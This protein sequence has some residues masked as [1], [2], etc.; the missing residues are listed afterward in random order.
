MFG[1]QLVALERIARD[2]RP[3]VY[4]RV[5]LALIGTL[6]HDGKG[7]ARVDG[8]VLIVSSSLGQRDGLFGSQVPAVQ[9]H[10]AARPCVVIRC[11]DRRLRCDH[12]TT[13]ATRRGLLVLQVQLT[14]R[15]GGRRGQARA[16]SRGQ[17]FLFEYKVVA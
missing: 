7:R 14:W 9:P 10:T 2:R 4:V 17:A 3:G 11:F 12:H 13:R 16:I 8:V 1:A 15:C 6:E 5:F